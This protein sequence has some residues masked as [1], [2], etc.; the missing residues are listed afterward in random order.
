M[1][2]VKALGE[3]IEKHDPSDALRCN[4]GCAQEIVRHLYEAGF[5]IR[6]TSRAERDAVKAISVAMDSLP[7]DESRKKVA[8]G[9]LSGL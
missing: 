6:P 1:E 2:N 8:A 3:A 5:I 7:S 4:A 9:V